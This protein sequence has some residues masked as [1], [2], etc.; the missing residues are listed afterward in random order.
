MLQLMPLLEAEGK[1]FAKKSLISIAGSLNF[2][3]NC[4][5]IL[6]F[7]GLPLLQHASCCKATVASALLWTGVIKKALQLLPAD[8]Q[9]KALVF[10]ADANTSLLDAIRQVP[11]LF[12]SEANCLS[13][14]PLKHCPLT[15]PRLDV[16]SSQCCSTRRTHR[17]VLL[18]G[19]CF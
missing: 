5:E 18:A 13:D 14:L 6:Q 19:T 12:A 17:Q 10:Q 16:C 7:Y 11:A 9:D 4:R 2:N 1:A 8:A 3:L 15:H